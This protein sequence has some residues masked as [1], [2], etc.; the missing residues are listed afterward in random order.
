MKHTLSLY[1]AVKAQGGHVSFHTPGHK[2]RCP[3]IDALANADTTEISA[4]DE[5]YHPEG[6]I[7]EAE[8][9]AA[10]VFGA[11]EVCFS[12]G[13]ATLCIQT[14]LAFYAGKRALAERSCHISVVNASALLG[15]ELDFIW[16]ETDAD[17]GFALPLTPEKAEEHLSKG[18]Y[19][20]LVVTSPDYYG[21]CADL[22]GIKE[23][24]ER[25]SCDLIID[26]SHGS[27]LPFI[28]GGDPRRDAIRYGDFI[29]NSLHKTLPVMT[30]GAVLCVNKDLSK[31]QIKA[32]MALFGSTSPSFPV[33]ASIDLGV[34]YMWENA[35]RYRKT[36]ERVAALAQKIRAVGFRVLDN[37]EGESLRLCIDTFSVGYTAE[38]TEK[39]LSQA[40]IYPEIAQD[41][42][43]LLLFSP[44]NGEEDLEKLLAVLSSMEKR[45]PVSP[46]PHKS[47]TPPK[48]VT[49][50]R[51]ALLSPTE[52]VPSATSAGRISAETFATCPPGMAVV[53]AGE[54]ITE[55]AAAILASHKEYTEVVNR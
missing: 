21:L 48:R 6:P 20:V 24:C 25:Y 35:D 33:L 54:E 34:H 31:E 14:A 32:K 36:S 42:R 41:N 11:R 9:E 17:F 43:L 22:R 28:Y 45:P 5:L 4:T 3:Q 19:S 39:I 2:F 51:D 47:V 29:I 53:V 18:G 46:K 52:K 16:G 10:E 12:A 15:I 23:V 27:H 37:S 8:R 50:P 1:N 13:G 7:L 38:E 40:G 49:S 55:E 26:N 44:F 30:G